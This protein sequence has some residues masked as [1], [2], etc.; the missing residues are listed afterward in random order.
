MG[1]RL[2]WSLGRCVHASWG[3]TVHHFASCVL[4][5]PPFPLALVMLQRSCDHLPVPGLTELIEIKAKQ[6]TELLN[7]TDEAREWMVLGQQLVSQ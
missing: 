7:E 1:V 4:P 5:V 2:L 3:Q 6:E